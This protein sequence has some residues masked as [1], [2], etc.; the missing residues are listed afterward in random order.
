[1]V[2]FEQQGEPVDIPI[3]VKLTYSSG[4]S[5]EVVVPVVEKVTEQRIPL[6]GPLR[7][8]EANAD[9]GALAVIVK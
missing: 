3:T 2:R 9:H 5:A 8:V 6:K 4:D 7:S 1:M